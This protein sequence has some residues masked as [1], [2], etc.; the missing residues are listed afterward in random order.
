MLL[1]TATYAALLTNPNTTGEQAH[2]AEL[3]ANERHA[4]LPA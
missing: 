1:L 4:A 2:L 3:E